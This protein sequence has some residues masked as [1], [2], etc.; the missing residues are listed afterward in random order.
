MRRS[1]DKEHP[2]VVP[3]PADLYELRVVQHE[4]EGLEPGHEP[5]D[6]RQ[7]DGELLRLRQVLVVPGELLREGESGGDR[8]TGDTR[9]IQAVGV[10]GGNVNLVVEKKRCKSRW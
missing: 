1:G 6:V 10:V 3:P 2:G 8:V 5:L 4:P 9:Q 7:R